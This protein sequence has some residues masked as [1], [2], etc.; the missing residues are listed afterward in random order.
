MLAAPKGLRERSDDHPARRTIQDG[1]AYEPEYSGEIAG[2]RCLKLRDDIA[3]VV[4]EH[5]TSPGAE[6]DCVI[7]LCGR[8]RQDLVDPALKSPAQFIAAGRVTLQDCACIGSRCSQKRARIR[9]FH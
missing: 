3:R 7:T 4:F 5:T 1:E 2:E 9:S 8:N 6:N